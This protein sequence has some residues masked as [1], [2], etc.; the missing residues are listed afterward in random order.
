MARPAPALITP[1]LFTCEDTPS[2]RA[3]S[4]CKYTF[5]VS[6]FAM[7]TVCP[8]ASTAAAPSALTR[9]VLVTAAPI[10]YTPPP[11]ARI[12]PSLTK[13]VS[14][15]AN[16]A[17]PARNACGVISN[18]EATSPATFTCAS[19][20]N[21]MPF[22]LISQT[23]PLLLREPK[24]LDGSVPVTR[25]NTCELALCCSKFTLLPAPIEKLFQLIAVF[26]ALV[27]VMCEPFTWMLA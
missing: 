6:M 9:P 11:S 12:F 15:P 19:L 22:G 18:V 23:L 26:G 16:V 3:A 14:P 5:G 1:L 4:T 25:L 17:W 13:R 21:K 27:T 24:I 10:R 7:L 20:P 8:A 2:T